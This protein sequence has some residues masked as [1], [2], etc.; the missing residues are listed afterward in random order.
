[1]GTIDFILKKNN[2]TKSFIYDI[3]NKWISNWCWWKGGFNFSKFLENIKKTPSFD[4]IKFSKF[5]DDLRVVC[6]FHDYKFFV[7]WNFI[8]FIV[9]NLTLANDIQQLTHW[10]WYI[11]R[12]ATFLAVFLWTT[13]F[14]WKYFNFYNPKWKN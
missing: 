3:E 6:G 2:Y 12:I 10:R 14:G 11:R 1:M 4:E 13:L 7:W 8:D 5:K 9:A